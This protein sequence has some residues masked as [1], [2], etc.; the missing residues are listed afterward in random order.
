MWVGGGTAKFVTGSV[1]ATTIVTDSRLLTPPVETVEDCGILYVPFCW[2]LIPTVA[3]A[4]EG[5]LYLTMS[6]DDFA[7]KYGG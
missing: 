6:D 7:G 1:I 5:I 2:T 4:I 3:G